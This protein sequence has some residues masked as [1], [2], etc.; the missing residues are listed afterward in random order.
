MAVT[1]DGPNKHIILDTATSFA[2]LDIYS[3]SK[4]WEDDETNMQH[5]RPFDCSDELLFKLRYGWKFKPSGYGAGSTL[6]ING[7]LTTTEGDG[8]VVTVPATSGSQVTWQFN[9]PATA[10]IVATG[11]GVTAQDKT[12]IIEGLLT[13][14]R[15]LTI[16]D[17]MGLR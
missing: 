2:L 8:Q 1:F 7:K 17:Y 15:T 13:D 10:V 3:D 14:T 9:N 12:D 11:S 6:L 16:P 5:E 4:R